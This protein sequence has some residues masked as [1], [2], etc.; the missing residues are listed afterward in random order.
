MPFVGCKSNKGA[1]SVLGA[2]KVPTE[3]MEVAIAGFLAEIFPLIEPGIC[4]ILRRFS[5]GWAKVARSLS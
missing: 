3:L 2:E 5:P 1:A 4:H